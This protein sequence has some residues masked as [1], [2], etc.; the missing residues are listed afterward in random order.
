M[1][2]EKSSKGISSVSGVSE[3][4]QSDMVGHWYSSTERN[5]FRTSLV[6]VIDRLNAPYLRCY[7][8]FEMFYLSWSRL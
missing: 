5:P 6:A 4:S 8:A 3:N 2:D 7:G 1:I